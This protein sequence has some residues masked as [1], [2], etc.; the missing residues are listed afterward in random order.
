M[1]RSSRERSTLNEVF[2]VVCNAKSW[3]TIFPNAP[4]NSGWTKVAAFA[5]EVADM[6][7]AIWDSRVS[8]AV[9]ENLQRV[10]TSRVP[11]KD[12]GLR[13]IPGRGGW[14]QERQAALRDFGWRSGWGSRPWSA[15][16]AGARLIARICEMLNADIAK[17]SAPHHHCNWTI[18]T[19]EMALFMEGY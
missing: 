6:P 15:H 14:R 4:M 1:G 9:I 10:I 16:F 13:L 11:V 19:V 12:F 17:Y 3:R 5:S 7:Q 2:R 8:T 18:R